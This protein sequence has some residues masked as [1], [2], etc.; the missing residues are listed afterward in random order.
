MTNIQE[1]RD[2]FF[3]QGKRYV[4]ASAIVCAALSFG[5][6]DHIR[7]NPDAWEGLELASPFAL[8][9]AVVFYL[10]SR[11]PN[12]SHAEGHQVA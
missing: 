7:T 11:Q 12:P 8:A 3:T 2:K 5:I 10:Y 1:N 6:A 9:C 4:L